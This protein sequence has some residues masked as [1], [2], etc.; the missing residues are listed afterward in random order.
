MYYYKLLATYKIFI[1]IIFIIIITISTIMIIVIIIIIIII[2]SNSSSSSSYT[3]TIILCNKNTTYHKDLLPTLFTPCLYSPH[4]PF[5]ESSFILS[6]VYM[7]I[8]DPVHPKTIIYG[9][10]VGKIVFLLKNLSVH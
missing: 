10:L 1:V 4:S 3:T 7:W 5:K 9:V 6:Q 8:Y 2:S